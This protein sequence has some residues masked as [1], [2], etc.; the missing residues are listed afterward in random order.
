MTTGRDRSDS[1]AS[2]KNVV[3]VIG[4]RPEAIKMLPVYLALKRDGSFRTQLLSTGQHRQML[5]QVFSVFGVRPDV[6]LNLM[7]PDQSLAQLMANVVTGVQQAL[8]DTRP[9][10]VLVH[11]DTN[12]CLGAAIAAFYERIDIGHVEAG[13]RT[14]NYE[15]PWPEEMNRRLTDAICRWCFAPT[16]SAAG[17]L[18]AEHIAPGNI[19]VTGNTGID[20]LL[21]AR[22]MVRGSRPVL[23]DVLRGVL[24]GARLILVTG[25]RRESFGEPFVQ[26]CLALRDIVRTMPD[27]A[28][29]YPV[30]LNP[31]VQRPVREALAGEDRIYLVPPLDY[32]PFV[33]LMDRCELI[34]TDSGGIQEEAPSLH[35]PVLVTREVTE[36]PE[37]VAAGQAKLVGTSR[38]RI[39]EEACRLLSDPEAYEAMTRGENP[40]GDGRASE[41]IVCAL[42]ES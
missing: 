38:L 15:A 4:T 2:A 39:A 30:H 42:R 20:A 19:F 8:R 7:C 28:L 5:D 34:I 40:Y 22:D 10:M 18:R 17:N 9:D 33:Y 32:L 13:L 16:A 35:K 36:R 37:A 14:Y 41:R 1:A 12:T 31:N 26:F 23:P 21:M 3:V 25:H 11:G 24:D 6:D 27:T 29:V